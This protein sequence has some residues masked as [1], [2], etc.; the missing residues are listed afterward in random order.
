MLFYVLGFLAFFYIGYGAA[1][2]YQIHVQ[3]KDRADAAGIVRWYAFTEQVLLW[4][5]RLILRKRQQ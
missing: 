3:I 2:A 1:K 4:L 5:P